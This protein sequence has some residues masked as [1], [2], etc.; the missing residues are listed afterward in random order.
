MSEILKNCRLFVWYTG[1]FSLV[2]NLLVLMPIIY[3]LNVFDRVMSNNSYATLVTLTLL[4]VAIMLFGTFLETVQ[5]RLLNRFGITLHRLLGQPILQG[6]LALKY[7]GNTARHG[8]EDVEL[9]QNFIITKGVK[10]L[11]DLPWVPFYVILLYFFHPVFAGYALVSLVLLAILAI[12]EHKSTTAL[13]LKSALAAREVGD[14]LSGILRNTEIINAQGMQDAII[15]RWWSRNE[16][17]LRQHND[18]ESSIARIHAIS[19]FFKHVIDTLALGSAAYLVVTENLSTGIMIAA[20]MLLSR[21]TAPIS[22]LILA[23]K[24]FVEAR[25]AYGRLNSLLSR[26]HELSTE[27]QVQTL[28]GHLSVQKLN[29]KFS[30]ERT[31]LSSVSFDLLA[32]ETLAIIGSSGSGKTT[33]A[34]LLV[35]YYLLQEGKIQFDG[36]D[37]KLWANQN[38]GKQIGYLPQDLQLF[39]GTVAENI[40]R[41]EPIA[42]NEE[43]II[44]A[45]RHARV[46]EMILKLPQGYDTEIGERGAKLSGGQ[47]QR[48]ALAR[49]LYGQPKFLVLDEPNS[50]LDG[51]AEL[52]LLEI[53]QE[54][55]QQHVTVVVISHKPNLVEKADKVL[56][57]HEGTVFQFGQRET[58]FS[59]ISMG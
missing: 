27:T 12:W 47:R 4:V 7:Q 8:L 18:I 30:T 31:I 43:K 29:F 1:L 9:L 56:A 13:Q 22:S 35:G 59:Q 44:A 5:A 37:I 52:A 55:K 23:G 17:Y 19:N 50:N 48:L 14:Y 45:A 39:S 21:A 20:T 54:L 32:G 34:K 3:M 26:N 28:T 16:N 46:H 6:M 24:S 40:A 10:A 2:L 57:L 51:A 15:E 49:A 36:M 11:F 53:L 58:V 33:L 25:A 41:L 42:K 38:L